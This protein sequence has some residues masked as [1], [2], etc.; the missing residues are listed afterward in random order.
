MVV[1]DGFIFLHDT[2]PYDPIMFDAGQCNDVY[3]TALYIKQ[4]LS[5]DFEC[6]TLPFNPGVT[7]IKKMSIDKQ[8]IYINKH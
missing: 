4:N 2:Y 6:L 1:E 8:L 7:I 3:K 5:K